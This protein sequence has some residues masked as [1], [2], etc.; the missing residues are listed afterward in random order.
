M[1][2]ALF[3]YDEAIG[4]SDRG[5]KNIQSAAVAAGIVAL[6][7]CSG[8]DALFRYGDAVN[9]PDRA[10]QR[11]SDHPRSLGSRVGEIPT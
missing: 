3:R 5:A 7:D 2:D 10:V 6:T 11:W 9:R 1:E 8:P 4:R